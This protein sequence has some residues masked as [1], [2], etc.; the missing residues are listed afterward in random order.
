MLTPPE[1]N[2]CSGCRGEHR[3]NG[4]DLILSD[5]R[6]KKAFPEISELSWRLLSLTPKLSI[7]SDT[8]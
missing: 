8:V 5:V 1:P 2:R 3:K 4:L 7:Q 6:L